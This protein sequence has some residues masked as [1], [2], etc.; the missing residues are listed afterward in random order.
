MPL[1]EPLPRRTPW[2]AIVGRA[3]SGK[4]RAVQ[5]VADVCRARGY[6]VGGVVQEPVLSEERCVGYDVV[7]LASGER[8]AIARRSPTPTMCEWSFDE[9]AFARAREWVLRAG[10][11]VTAFE[12]GNLEAKGGGH[13]P[14]IDEAFAGPSRLILLA[15][16]P[17]VLGS[18]G[19]ELDD[20]VCGIELP[21]SADG[22]AG[23]AARVLHCLDG[24]ASRR[25][26]AIP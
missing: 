6:S 5:S 26:A 24:T 7:D 1:P 12:V 15:I 10:T 17:Q 8:A 19:L 9:S 3:Q 2:A 21:A 4:R 11:D 16:R 18:I 25:E 13:R 23:F 22:I 20:P 14:A